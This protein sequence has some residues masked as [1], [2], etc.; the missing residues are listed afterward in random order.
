MTFTNGEL[1]R[2]ATR[3]LAYLAGTL[4]LCAIVITVA[5][6][7]TVTVKERTTSRRR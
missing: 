6:A 3:M 7:L 5:V 1:L 2:A 4:L